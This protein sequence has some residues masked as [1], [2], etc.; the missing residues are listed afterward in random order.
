LKK[1]ARRAR[2]SKGAWVRTAI[3]ERLAQAGGVATADPL[4]T[5]A[6][7]GAPTADIGEMLAQIEAGRT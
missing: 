6:E 3:E 1:A 4:E 2:V 7:L 5:M